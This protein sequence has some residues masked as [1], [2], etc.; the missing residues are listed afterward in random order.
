MKALRSFEASVAVCP[1]IIRHISED[2]NSKVL[3]IFE[4]QVKNDTQFWVVDI[5]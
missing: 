5:G 2:L 3:V 4:L 1:A